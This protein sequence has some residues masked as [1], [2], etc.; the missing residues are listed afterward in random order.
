MEKAQKHQAI[1]AQ[2]P[3]LKPAHRP[4]KGDNTQNDV[5]LSER[6]NSP[7]YALARLRKDRPDIHARVLAGELSPHAGMIEDDAETLV[8]FREAV[9]GKVGRPRKN[10]SNPTNNRKP[11]RGR[12]L[13][14]ERARPEAPPSASNSITQ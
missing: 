7:S 14:R 10:S 6:G 2:T 11:D 5:T 12:R 9:T 4:K 1:D 13:N 8:A 3:D